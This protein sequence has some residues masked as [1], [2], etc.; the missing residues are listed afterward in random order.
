[1]SKCPCKINLIKSKLPCY[2][3]G[4]KE[5]FGYLLWKCEGSVRSIKSIS[6]C[7]YLERV[8]AWAEKEGIKF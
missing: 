7:P 1:M 3:S 8:K 6:T 2:G 4:Q 5:C